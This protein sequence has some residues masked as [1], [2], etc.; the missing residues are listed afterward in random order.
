M[1]LAWDLILLYRRIA[2]AQMEFIED[3]VDMVLTVETSMCR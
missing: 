2:I 1:R 3:I